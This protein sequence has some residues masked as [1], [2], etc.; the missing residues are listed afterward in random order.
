MINR[1]ETLYILQSG[2]DEALREAEIAKFTELAASFGG[3]VAEVNK[4]GTKKFAYEINDKREGY[5]VLMTFT[6]TADAVAEI[7]RKM[8]ISDMVVRYKTTRK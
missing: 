6:A 4:W 3:E 7:E 2:V 5:Y 8:R 1:Y